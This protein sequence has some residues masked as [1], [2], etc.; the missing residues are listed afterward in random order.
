MPSPTTTFRLSSRER[1]QL[2]RLANRLVCSRTDVLRYGLAALRREDFGWVNQIRADNLARAFLKNLITQYGEDAVIELQDGPSDS[3]W[4]LAGEPLDSDLLDVVI[5]RQGDG[6]VIDLLDKAHGVGISNVR[7]W[8]DEHGFRHATVALRDLWV[9]SST[10]VSADPKTRQLA[11]GRAVVQFQ[12]DDGTSR[13]LVIDDQGN[14]SPIRRDDVPT[15][16]LLELPPSI[17]VGL[18]RE[19]E[20]GPH[21]GHGL[22][23]K[24]E[25]TGDIERDRAAAVEILKE[26]LVR[27]ERGEADEILATTQ[28]SERLS[29]TLNASDRTSSG[30][31]R[32][33]DGKSR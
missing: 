17:G 23:A 11:D 21:L 7:A 26:L 2:D 32:D 5:R 8:E 29:L 15:A 25:L 20:F 24:H 18:R 30:A 10:R 27:V 16:S 9:Y 3:C 12:E 28:G 14:S 1:A 4:R 22:G 31:I 33:D 13:E 6:Y 19:S